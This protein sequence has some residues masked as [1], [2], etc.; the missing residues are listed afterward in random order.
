MEQAQ[1]GSVGGENI[2]N[3]QLTFLTSMQVGG[4]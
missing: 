4:A 3:T 1:E 2:W